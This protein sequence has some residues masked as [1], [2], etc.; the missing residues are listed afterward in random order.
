[1]AIDPGVVGTETPAARMRVERGRLQLFCK[2]IGETDPV[3]VD[4]EAARAA[5][6]PDL[7]V[8]P[9][10]L[11]SIQNELPEPMAWLSAIGVDPLHVLHGEQSFTYYGDAHA[12]D[13]L[14]V[15]G[16][17]TDLAVKKNGQME[18]LTRDSVVTDDEGRTLAELRDIIVVRHPEVGK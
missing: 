3:Y 16:R 1:M 15:L 10:F 2:A 8:P 7:L 9:T 5:G 4:L 14:T 17:I 13:V 12:N 11:C 18:L 6:H